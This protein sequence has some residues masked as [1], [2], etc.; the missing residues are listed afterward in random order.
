MK[1]A[2]DA[3][4][5]GGQSFQSVRLSP[6]SIA[7][8][9]KVA[10]THPLEQTR[11]RPWPLPQRPWAL[12]MRWTDLAFLH[13]PVPADLL[14][15]LIPPA[16]ALDTYDGMA[17]LGVVP[18]RMEGTRVRWAPSIPTATTFPEAN[19]RTYVTGAGRAGVWFFSLDA[20]SRLATWAAR[21]ALALPYHYARMRI[22][23]SADQTHY[24]SARLQPEPTPAVLRASYAATGSV[25]RSTPGALDHWL[26]ERYCLFGQ[27][28]SGAV[29]YLDIHH[30]P[31]PLE[32]GTAHVTE[33]KL[34]R[35]IGVT[36]PRTPLL[37]HLAKRLDVW[38]WAPVTLPPDHTALPS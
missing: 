27:R 34:T 30:L 33:V 14:R 37:V 11:H 13:W 31:W 22:D 35:A 28:R 26:T 24:R 8:R 5:E 25:Y 1:R 15:P 4:G 17:W 20:G 32:P 7:S 2:N 36:V 10:A 6:L 21:L 19:L 9:S 12:F 16:L 38:A 3:P 18:F 23:P 29:Y